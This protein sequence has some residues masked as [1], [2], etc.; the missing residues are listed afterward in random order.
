MMVSCTTGTL[1]AGSDWTIV[2]TYTGSAGVAFSNFVTAGETAPGDPSHANNSSTLNSWFGPA[3]DLSV[4]QAATA[5]TAPGKV[6]ITDTIKNAGPWTAQHLQLTAKINSPTFASLGISSSPAATCSFISPP[7][8]FTKALLCTTPTL[9]AGQ[10]WTLTF[11]ENGA[12]GG[13][14][15][16][17]AH[18]RANQPTDPAPANNTAATI[19]THYA[20]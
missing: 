14:V 2:F 15:Q 18:V 3:A 17:S 20:P 19:T 4:Q 8:G 5:G 7:P 10:V 13:S 12:P 6:T 9:A 16:Q 11:R 1:G